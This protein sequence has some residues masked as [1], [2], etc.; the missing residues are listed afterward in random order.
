MRV[1]DK[2]PEAS[3]IV[4]QMQNYSIHDGDGVRTTIFLAGC[5]LRCRWCANPESWT[6]KPKLVFHQHRCD[7]CNACV[8]VC[9]KGIDPK[10]RE[11]LVQCDLCGEC[12]SAC[13][14]KALDIAGK[15]LSVSDVLTKVKKDQLFFR[16]TGGGVTF[17]GGE[18]FLQAEFLN[19]IVPKLEELG[20]GMWAESCGLFNLNSV[21]DI[22]DKFDHLFIDIKHMN[23][24]KHKQ[25][26]GHGNERILSNIQDI[27]AMG[28]PMTIR[29]PLIPSVNDDAENLQST[30]RFMLE[31]LPGVKVEILPY[32]E[33][34]KSKFKS[35]G[36]EEL[37]VSYRVPSQVEVDVAYEY[38][39]QAG[40]QIV[41]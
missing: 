17:S 36:M 35:L 1:M 13:P 32:H 16:H 5:K 4:L 11:Q 14:S 40:I 15:N 23:S 9:S 34:G 37:W 38:F 7:E 12:V 2:I 8:Q 21:K 10:V 33:L 25:V 3:A 41:S 20:I 26:T 27:F 22:L 31:N 19:Q 28:V 30:A 39:R 29:I 6:L 24:D 18:P